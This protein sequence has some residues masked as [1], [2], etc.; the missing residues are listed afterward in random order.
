LTLFDNCKRYR[1]NL[2]NHFSNVKLGLNAVVVIDS[3]AVPGLAVAV[4][5]PLKYIRICDI[6][7]NVFDTERKGSNNPIIHISKTVDTFTDYPFLKHSKAFRIP[8]NFLSKGYVEFEV[9]LA[10]SSIITSNVRFTDSDF[11]VSIV[12]Y[13]EDYEDSNDTLLAAPV[14]RE[15]PNKYFNNY[16]PNYNNT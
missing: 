13:E 14:P 6:S 7:D 12:V 3:I 11:A 4:N 15:P 2:K 1:F 5:D 10:V 16:F 9:T 8:Q